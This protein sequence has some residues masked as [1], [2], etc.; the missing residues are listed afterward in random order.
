MPLR[1][2]VDQSILSLRKALQISNVANLKE[3]L[4][5]VA[6]RMSVRSKAD[7]YVMGAWIRL[8]LKDKK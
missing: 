6:L 4:P 1:K 3:M 5:D 7:P 8:C 2:T